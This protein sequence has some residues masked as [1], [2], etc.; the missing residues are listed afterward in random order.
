M[1]TNAEIYQEDLFAENDVNEEEAP[2]ILKTKDYSIFN[3]MP[4]N[5]PLTESHVR[6]LMDLLGKNNLLKYKPILV[7]EKKEV[8]DGQHRLEAAKR[9]GLTIYYKIGKDLGYKDAAILNACTD[10][11]QFKEFMKAYV[12]NGHEAYAVLEKF[13]ECNN[14]NLKKFYLVISKEQKKVFD[15]SFKIGGFKII[16]NLDEISQR[17]NKLNEIIKFIEQVSLLE[18]KKFL[19][20]ES[21]WR[22]LYTLLVKQDVDI[23]RFKEKISYKY[24]SIRPLGGYKDYLQLFTD[25]Y[26]WKAKKRLE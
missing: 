24:Q 26:N 25:I 5:R 20:T 8:I 1:S 4:G 22:A 13:I 6:N 10:D 21:C 12:E 18:N 23:E 19:N 11:W 14:L 15:D 17:L 9:L 2:I 3:K 16:D 7:N